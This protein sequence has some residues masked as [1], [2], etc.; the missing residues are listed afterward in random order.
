MAAAAAG[1]Q[2]E[3]AT[4]RLFRSAHERGA[5][6]ADELEILIGHWST[7]PADLDTEAKTANLLG[8]IRERFTGPVLGGGNE[9][10][11]GDELLSVL[12]VEQ[13]AMAEQHVKQ[14]LQRQQE[15]KQLHNQRVKQ[16][17]DEEKRKAEQ[18]LLAK[19]QKKINEKA[20]RDEKSL[21]A[22]AAGGA[23]DLQ[24][25]HQQQRLNQQQQ[26]QMQLNLPD[27][28]KELM[29]GSH[30]ERD[31][32][33]LTTV[34][35]LTSQKLIDLDLETSEGDQAKRLMREGV[36]PIHEGSG[37]GV[38]ATGDGSGTWYETNLVDYQQLQRLYQNLEANV[39]M[40]PTGAAMR[41]VSK[42][43]QV[44]ASSVLGSAWQQA[45]RR[46]SADTIDDFT[47]LYLIAA[48]DP[49]ARGHMYSMKWGPD[50]LGALRAEE[51]AAH[52]AAKS[53]AEALVQQVKT[54]VALEQQLHLQ[55]SIAEAEAAEAGGGG[56]GRKRKAAEADARAD[57]PPF[58]VND[59]NL[60][61]KNML[62]LEQ[63]ARLYFVEE[64]LPTG[65]RGG[66]VR[67]VAA[68]AGL[69][70]TGQ[71]GAGVSS[72][73]G[74]GGGGVGVGGGG[75]TSLPAPAEAAALVAA[76]DTAA[77]AAAAGFGVDQLAQL[78]AQRERLLAALMP[79]CPVVR[80]QHTV[81]RERR[82]VKSDVLV[83]LADVKAAVGST[84][85]LKSLM[86]A[87]EKGGSS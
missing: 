21:A 62:G 7:V 65:K 15:L 10:S 79:E 82:I 72:G 55:R 4:F 30:L 60:E 63:L 16:Q 14:V 86:F 49:T 11:R 80:S 70:P 19:K 78:K 83:A 31:D 9:A 75:A 87:K 39:K 17:Q 58:W 25:F 35:S 34:G 24:H 26:Q 46:T 53:G 61:R 20:K 13:N 77:T 37:A 40:V 64:C 29:D 67:D 38:G 66:G 8:F 54:A 6:G 43:V 22:V 76:K 28:F 51:S 45:Q 18:K 71:P 27:I 48:E 2:R 84:A 1:Q 23:P 85:V 52:A 59:Q 41:L 56:G 47:K 73:S 5:L 36:A 12:R 69:V 57:P 3:T 50:V 44:H 68:P 42:A 81:E 74:S 32:V 33:N